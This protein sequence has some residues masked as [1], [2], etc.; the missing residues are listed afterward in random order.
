MTDVKNDWISARAYALWERDGQAH[1]K[2]V[3]HWQQAAAE[4]ERRDRTRA[5]VDG[6]DVKLVRAKSKSESKSLTSGRKLKASLV[7]T[8]A[9][10][11]VV[12][13]EI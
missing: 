9:V 3:Q 2:D 8:E 4:Y 5:S 10:Q 1:G 6:A 12:R 7:S 11:P 13:A